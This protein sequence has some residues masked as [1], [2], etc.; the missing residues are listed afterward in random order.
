MIY[1]TSDDERSSEA[2]K[3]RSEDA[4]AGGERRKSRREKVRSNA[5]NLRKVMRVK[6]SVIAPLNPGP[7][8]T[9]SRP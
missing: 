7:L 4:I 3:C 9:M 2:T 1:T 5:G 6:L 8:H